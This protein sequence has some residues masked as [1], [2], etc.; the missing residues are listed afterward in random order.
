MSEYNEESYNE[1]ML[2]LTE[3]HIIEITEDELLD[4]M[5][6]NK[7]VQRELNKYI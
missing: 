6:R 7:D 3:D 1:D 2:Y 5:N 4:H